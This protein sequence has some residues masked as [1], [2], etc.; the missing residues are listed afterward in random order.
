MNHDRTGR[1]D[2]H[3]ATVIGQGAFGADYALATGTRV[4]RDGL[5]TT[6]D[7]RCACG[8]SARYASTMTFLLNEYMSFLPEDGP[9]ARLVPN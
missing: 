2:M 1:G 7:D 4:Y 6:A 5:V 8:Q 9:H 3:L